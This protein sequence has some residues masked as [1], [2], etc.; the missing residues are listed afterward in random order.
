MTVFFQT[1]CVALETCEK[2]AANRAFY[3]R[4]VRHAFQAEL[5]ENLLDRALAFLGK[6]YE[7]F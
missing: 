4:A 1:S 5:T 6:T 7:V 2:I 3:V